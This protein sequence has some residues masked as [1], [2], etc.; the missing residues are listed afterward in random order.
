MRPSLSGEGNSAM[1]DEER[2]RRKQGGSMERKESRDSQPIKQH[3][4]AG[5]DGAHYDPRG[6]ALPR[7]EWRESNLHFN[8]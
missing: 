6:L 2:S 8:G 1:G 3:L 7:S 4:A 5:L